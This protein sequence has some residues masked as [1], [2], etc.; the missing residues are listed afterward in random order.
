MVPVANAPSVALVVLIDVLSNVTDVEAARPRTSWPEQSQSP[1]V[2][3][4]PVIL[5]GV[6]VAAADPAVPVCVPDCVPLVLIDVPAMAF[7]TDDATWNVFVVTLE[8]TTQTTVPDV[9]P[10]GSAPVVVNTTGHAVVNPCA[11]QVMTAGDAIV[12]VT[13]AVTVGPTQLDEINSPT[14][15]ALALSFVVVPGT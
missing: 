6:A 7:N 15:P 14:L 11:V 2:N 3:A 12:I 5:M 8:G 4:T 10:V 1:A 13:V 9:R